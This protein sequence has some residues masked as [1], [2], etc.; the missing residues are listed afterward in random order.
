MKKMSP[1]ERVIVEL[2]QRQALAKLSANYAA[3]QHEPL[4]ADDIAGTRAVLGNLVRAID[5]TRCRALIVPAVQDPDPALVTDGHALADVLQHTVAATGYRDLLTALLLERH[6]GMIL[7][8]EDDQTGEQAIAHLH[9]QLTD[10][11]L[12]PASVPSTTEH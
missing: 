9:Q 8:T 12:A 11:G 6:A 4:T 2:S 7:A 1:T 10:L 3:V 5:P